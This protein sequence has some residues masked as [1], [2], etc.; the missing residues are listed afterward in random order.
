M[1]S[2][3]MKLK[4]NGAEFQGYGDL[5]LYDKKPLKS[6]NEKKKDKRKNNAGYRMPTGSGVE[7]KK[8]I[9]M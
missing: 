8:G 7:R 5:S 4:A 9:L 3:V 1:E 6:L 2:L